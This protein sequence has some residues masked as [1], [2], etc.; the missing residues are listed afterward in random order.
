MIITIMVIN[1]LMIFRK[2]RK[3]K[4]AISLG[5]TGDCRT[6]SRNDVRSVHFYSG[7]R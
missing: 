6:G 2:L 7:D 4:P 5:I 3:N 1:I